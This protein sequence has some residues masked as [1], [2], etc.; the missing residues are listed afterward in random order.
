[1]NCSFIWKK[2]DITGKK[3]KMRFDPLYTGAVDNRSTDTENAP[4]DTHADQT[5]EG[6]RGES[7]ELFDDSVSVS[8]AG[9]DVGGHDQATDSLDD[10]VIFISSD[11]P[12]ETNER[13]K[14]ACVCACL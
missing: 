12:S 10:S 11:R 8:D 14:C 3:S 13:S 9:G 6:E 1:M 2:N 5:N 4:M 7:V